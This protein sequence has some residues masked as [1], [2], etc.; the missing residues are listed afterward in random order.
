MFACTL[1]VLGCWHQCSYVRSFVVNKAPASRQNA[2]LC[3]EF[4]K[5][6]IVKLLPV[7]LAMQEITVAVKWL[8]RHLPNHCFLCGIFFFF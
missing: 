5:E 1:L 2:F 3:F 6:P 4:L 8:A 7:R